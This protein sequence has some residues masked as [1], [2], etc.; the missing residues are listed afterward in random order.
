MQDGAVVASAKCIPDFVK[1]RLRKF[2]RQI[3][4]D[5]PR[6]SDAGRAP[7]ARHIRHTHIK[8]FGYTSLDLLD[9]NGM[10]SFFLQN[11]LQQMFDDFLRQ[12]LSA[13]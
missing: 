4:R 11:I 12:L 6:K 10:T 7:F 8:V 5:L 2:A 1:R 9:G 13:E 3:H